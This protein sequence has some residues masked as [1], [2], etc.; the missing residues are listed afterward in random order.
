MEEGPK[1][2]FEV[3]GGNPNLLN[4]DEEDLLLVIAFARSVLKNT[5]A[6]PSSGQTEAENLIDLNYERNRT[7]SDETNITLVE[8]VI[9][10]W[11]ETNYQ[12]EEFLRRCAEHMVWKIKES[13]NH[14]MRDA[15]NVSVVR[16]W[17]EI[18]DQILQLADP[19]E[20][21]KK[22]INDMAENNEHPV[23]QQAA[24]KT[25]AKVALLRQ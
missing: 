23:L 1:P 6:K 9:K 10:E 20:K 16:S 25:I 19:E 14:E 8:S 11:V 22:I 21:L 3:V 2:R 15:S 12:D 13:K 17:K 7:T 18:L 4:Q 5:D 24:Q